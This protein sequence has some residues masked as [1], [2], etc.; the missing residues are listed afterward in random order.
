MTAVDRTAAAADPTGVDRTAAADPAGTDRTGVDRTAD[1]RAP[2]VDL[3]AIGPTD[4][5]L[6]AERAA[7][8]PRPPRRWHPDRVALLALAVAGLVVGAGLSGGT[9]AP[10]PPAAQLL[11]TLELRGV[12]LGDQPTAVL[13]VGLQNVGAETVVADEITVSGAGLVPATRR[14]GRTVATGAYDTATVRVPLSCSRSAGQ[15]ARGTVRLRLLPSALPHEVLAEGPSTVSAVLV[16]YL[17]RHGGLCSAADAA[18]PDGWAEQARATSWTFGPQGS[19]LLVLGGLPADVT[20]LLAAQ[21][22][23]VIVPVPQAPVPVQGGSATVQLGAPRSGCRAVGA[24]AVV[25]TGLQFLAHAAEGSRYVYV[26]IDLTV[27]D[28]LMRAFVDA[29][30]DSP[31]GPSAVRPLLGG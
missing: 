9:S 24:R 31:G 8:S 1:D 7:P 19:L 6:D 17:A 15:P 16:G 27:A 18:L 29:C 14:I 26:P 25:P 10:A 20:D 13:T 11:V 3:A 12:A 4:V 2:A 5:D 21:A 30:P 23:G 22:D 28:W